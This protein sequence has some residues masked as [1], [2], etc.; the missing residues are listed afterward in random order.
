MKPDWESRFPRLF[1]PAY[2]DYANTDVIFATD[3][4]VEPLVT[5]LHCVATD[6]DGRVIVCRTEDWRFLPGGT[7]EPG[8]SLEQ[9]AARE[10][11]EEAGAKVT[12]PLTIFGAQFATSL[13]PAPYRSHQPHP[14]SCWAFATTT[15]ELIG[16]PENPP[17]GEQVLEV[18]VLDP[19]P[20]ADWLDDHDPVHADVVRL[21]VA[22]GLIA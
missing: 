17:D 5:R 4:V 9:T 14:K 18:V 10:L 7:R 12:G 22:M 19:L 1:E 11:L 16:P 6:P 3:G 15:A 13:N 2:V 8:E 20:A 21:A